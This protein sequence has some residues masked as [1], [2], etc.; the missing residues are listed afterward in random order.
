MTTVV[1][2]AM[3][4][5]D[6]AVDTDHNLNTMMTTMTSSV[7]SAGSGSETQRMFSGSSSGRRP[8]SMTFLAVS[9]I[10]NTYIGPRNK[11]EERG[12]VLAG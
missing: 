8:L 5:P 1:R 4:S 7:D 10:K 2:V 6:S 12:G 3:R 11:K 9:I